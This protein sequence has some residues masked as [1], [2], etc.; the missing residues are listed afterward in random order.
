MYIKVRLGELE[1]DGEG[2]G[3][4]GGYVGGS[5]LKI[6]TVDQAVYM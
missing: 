6:D 4:Y 3:R 2:R 1:G 5:I